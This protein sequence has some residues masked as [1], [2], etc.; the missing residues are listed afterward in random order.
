LI[1]TIL[2]FHEGS[3]TIMKKLIF[4]LA[5]GGPPMVMLELTPAR[6]AAIKEAIAWLEGFRD[7]TA[8]VL[9]EML[10]EV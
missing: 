9:R 1:S 5:S 4:V 7:E 2:I 10:E 6:L 8:D 3:I